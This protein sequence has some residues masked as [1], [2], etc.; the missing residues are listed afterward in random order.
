[1]WLALIATGLLAVAG[2]ANQSGSRFLAPSGGGGG[3]AP[4]RREIDDLIADGYDLEMLQDLYP[5][6]I[7]FPSHPD[8]VGVI[9]HTRDDGPILVREYLGELEVTGV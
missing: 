1:M 9:I 2:V 3:G 5:D 8:V 4:S 7:S 6:Y